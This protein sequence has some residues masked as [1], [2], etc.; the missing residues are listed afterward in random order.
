MRA[1][2]S[3]SLDAPLE[4]R[5]FK[6]GSRADYNPRRSIPGTQLL[7]SVATVSEGT[8]PIGARHFSSVGTLYSP[9]ERI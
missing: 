9:H 8:G 7:M 2:E 5:R 3:F 4:F 6:R 1:Q